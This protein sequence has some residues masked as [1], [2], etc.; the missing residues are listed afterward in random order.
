MRDLNFFEPYQ[1]KNKSKVSMN[2]YLYI[3][4]GIAGLIMLS[5][6]ITNVIKLGIIDGSIAGYTEKLE[7]P[8]IQKELKEAENINKQIDVL[9]QYDTALNDIN[10][11]VNKRSNVSDEL[12]NNVSSTIPS[13]ISFKELEVI[14]NT[15]TIEGTATNR[16]SIAELQH[17]LKQLSNMQ[18]VY[19]NEIDNEQSVEGEYS[20]NIKCVLKDVE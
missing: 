5:T 3:A 15:L 14:N 7:A 13:E 12:L 20:F 9:S 17:N 16:T 6:L 1:G 4:I 2:V 8:D 18:Y 19:V 11:S 10:N